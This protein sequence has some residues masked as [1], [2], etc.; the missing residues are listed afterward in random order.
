VTCDLSQTVQS[1]I[2]HIAP[3]GFAARYLFNQSLSMLFEH[4]P[5]SVIIS[6]KVHCGVE[7]QDKLADI[8]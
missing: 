2:L 8:I 1:S 4:L 3:Q 7:Q 5:Y 6:A